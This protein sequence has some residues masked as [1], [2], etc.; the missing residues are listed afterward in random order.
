MAAI[1]FRC[2]T[3][4]IVLNSVQHCGSVITDLIIHSMV[5]ID[6]SFLWMTGKIIY[7]YQPLEQS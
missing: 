5:I 1:S 4:C 3:H 2:V 7:C 6:P